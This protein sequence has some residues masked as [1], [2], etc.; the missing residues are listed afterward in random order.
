MYIL[1]I[2]EEK[3][4][5]ERDKSSQWQQDPL[6]VRPYFTL[7]HC[8][9]CANKVKPSE[10][11]RIFWVLLTSGTEGYPFLRATDL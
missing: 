10:A 6:L 7:H 5:K 2:R 9:L 1:G 3:L 4:L 11:L 8:G